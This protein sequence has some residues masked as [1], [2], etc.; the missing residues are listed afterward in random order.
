[1]KRERNAKDTKTAKSQTKS[2]RKRHSQRSYC[3]QSLTHILI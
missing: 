3:P 2:V 1:M